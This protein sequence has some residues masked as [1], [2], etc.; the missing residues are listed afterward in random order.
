MKE[1]INMVK[2]RDTPKKEADNPDGL[3]NVQQSANGERDLQVWRRKLDDLKAKSKK[4]NEQLENMRD[5]FK[6]IQK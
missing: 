5:R 6:E 3:M 4:K 2:N 1:M